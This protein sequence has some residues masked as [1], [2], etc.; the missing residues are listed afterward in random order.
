MGENVSVIIP[1]Y[2]EQNRI[3]RTLDSLKGIDMINEIIVADDGSTDMTY[4]EL[5]DRRDIVLLHTDKNKGKGE[6]VKRA[7]RHVKNNNVV[8]L[9]ADLCETAAEAAKLISYI[10][11]DKRR[12]I[13]GRLP[14]PVKKGGFGIVKSISDHGLYLLTGRHVLSLLSG[15]RVLPLE[16]LRSFEL[17]AGFGMEFKITLEALRQG[18]E[19]LEV[20]VNMKHRESQ[21]D[22][23][24]FVHRG[25]QCHDIVEV[26]IYEICNKRLRS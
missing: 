7:I 10:E 5:K 17:P 3:Q 20:P 25:R 6:A 18:Y 16:F 15:Q 21:R 13:I 19:L 9:D 23:K 4:M 24:G 12:I 11:P 8:L 26:I 2:N 1:A 14:S 22:I